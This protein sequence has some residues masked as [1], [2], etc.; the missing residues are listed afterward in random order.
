MNPKV[1][2]QRPAGLSPEENE[3]WDRKEAED[4]KALDQ[5]PPDSPSVP[6]GAGDLEKGLADL[7]KERGEPAKAVE[8]AP[9]QDYEQPTRDRIA[10]LLSKYDEA[11]K[12]KADED[13]R[14]GAWALVTGNALGPQAGEA[15]RRAW[16][17]GNDEEIDNLDRKQKAEANQLKS[18]DGLFSL[19]RKRRA[20][21]PNSPLSKALTEFEG[22]T[23]GF[24]NDKEGKSIPGLSAQDALDS[25]KGVVNPVFSQQQQTK[26]NDDNN[27]VK[28][29]EKSK[30]RTLAAD[31]G[32]RNRAAAQERA[33]TMARAGIAKAALG[34]DASVSS[35]AAKA[36]VSAGE[37]SIE[38]PNNLKPLVPG[39]QKQNYIIPK[40]AT[41]D[42]K[43][44]MREI[45]EFSSKSIASLE[46][47]KAAM[48]DPD[49]SRF[50]R[51][52][53]AARSNAML[54]GEQYKAGALQ[55]DTKLNDNGVLNPADLTL[56]NQAI[57][58]LDP[59]SFR[60]LLKSNPELAES[61]ERQL[62]AVKRSFSDTVKINTYVRG[63]REQAMRDAAGE[64]RGAN[65]PVYGIKGEILD[66]FGITKNPPI[67][68]PN[69]TPA[70]PSPIE[71]QGEPAKDAEYWKRKLKGI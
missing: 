49:S 58:G 45:A 60:S 44:R 59:A 66:Q 69:Y 32:R 30:D 19:A 39:D 62:Q 40:G 61:V 54:A 1:R 65:Q 5:T 2:S 15:T 16:G 27:T 38:L 9:E 23:T 71:G 11:S 50:E 28:V 37:G 68:Q 14:G 6:F 24:G 4:A 53:E 8:M 63:D 57:F 52:F 34:Q 46:L 47:L 21:D 22:R 41:Q 67:G 51:I 43:K 42:Q 25:G 33:E 7:R 18:E 36:G 26:R 10:D 31:E 20:S 35:G 17:M 56:G 64:F 13:R 48:L 70:A 3:A 12:R 55:S 29:E